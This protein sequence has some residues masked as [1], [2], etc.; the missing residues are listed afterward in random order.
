MQ[1]YTTRIT[2]AYRQVEIMGL[3]GYWRGLVACALAAGDLVELEKHWQYCV[4]V[5]DHTNPLYKD[6][7]RITKERKEGLTNGAC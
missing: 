4:K 2:E 5:S 1:P 7:A 6:L 3:V